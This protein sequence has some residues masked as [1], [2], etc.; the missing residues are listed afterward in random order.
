VE[1]VMRELT[2]VP[3]GQAKR[4][5]PTRGYRYAHELFNSIRAGGGALE[6]VVQQFARAGRFEETVV[7][8][9]N[10][11]QM[12]VAPIEQI[13]TDKNIDNQLVLILAKFAKFSWQTAK[14]ILQLRWAD[15]GLTQE[16]IDKAHIDFEALKPATAQRIMRFYQ[17][18]QGANDPQTAAT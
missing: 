3:A 10:V 14:A 5:P 11:C 4:G 16:A 15:G 7:A 2:G 12:P 17:I 1:E 9:A 8:L 6:P 18:R 13:M